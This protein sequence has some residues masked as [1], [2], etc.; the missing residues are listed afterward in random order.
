MTIGHFSLLLAWILSFYGLIAGLYGAKTSN[1]QISRSASRAVVLMGG[2]SLL[3]LIFLCVS[4]LTNDYSNLYVWQHSS[5]DMHPLYLIGAVWGGMDGSML[6][7]AVIMSLFAALVVLR[8]AAVPEALFVWVVPMLSGACAFFLTVVSAFT[9]PFRLIPESIS[10]FDGNGL[11]P[12]LQNPSMM[13]HPP[14]LYLGFTGFVVPFAFCLAALAS[15]QLSVSWIRLTRRWTLVSWCF[16]TAGI[17]LGGNWAYI[18]LGWGGFWAWDPVENASFMPWLTGTAFLHSVM[19][20]EH[21]GMLKVWNIMLAVLT[22]LLTVFGTFL[23]RSGVVQSVHAFAETDVGWVFL[24]YMIVLLV[25]VLV[26]L[27]LRWKSLKPDSVLQSYISREAAFLFNNLCLLAIL[28]TTLWGTMLPVITEAMTGEKSVVG[29]PFFNKVNNPLFLALLF[30]MAVGPLI[31]WRKNS[32]A[33]IRKT[34]IVP[35]LISGIIFISLVLIDSGRSLAA[36]RFF[37]FSFNVLITLRFSNHEFRSQNFKILSI[38][39]ICLSSIVS[40]YTFLSN[41]DAFI[42][43]DQILTCLSFSLSAL[44]VLTIFMDFYRA[45]KIRAATKKR[46][47][48]SQVVSLLK[49]KPRRYGAHLV[50]LGVAFAAISITASMAYKIERDLALELGAPQ[51]VGSYNLALLGLKEGSG[52]GYKSLSAEIEVSDAKTGEFITKMYPEK[53]AY[54]RST[55]VTTEVDIRS[56]L[57]EDLYIAFAGLEQIDEGVVNSDPGSVQNKR[58]VLKV[59]INPLQVWLWFSSLLILFGSLVILAEDLWIR[60]GKNKS[61]DASQ[62]ELG[63]S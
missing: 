36:L 14:L 63:V 47:L 32:I 56:T 17:V 45:A 19:V 11:N 21:R 55:E 20:Q 10:H 26:L 7:W 44:V 33:Q 5:N 34:F 46:N 51:K 39:T 62:V 50:H 35:V 18:E 30:L 52:Y 43:S 13:I 41:F 31:S 3:S 59:F 25:I 9:N 22:Y 48:P 8:K 4:F 54:S 15:N 53:R 2:L 49:S 60:I 61:L 23:T 58:A 12:L 6:L 27:S 16:L 37:A 1:I 40:I 28:V 29:P 24:A 38:L 42:H 57:K